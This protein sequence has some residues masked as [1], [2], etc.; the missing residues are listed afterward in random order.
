MLVGEG[1]FFGL[2]EGVFLRSLA[3]KMGLIYFNFLKLS[4]MCRRCQQQM[5]TL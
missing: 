3:Y 5:F 4:M 2:S 1:S